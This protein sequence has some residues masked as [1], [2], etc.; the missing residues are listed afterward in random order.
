MTVWY[1][2]NST[3]LREGIS[4]TDCFCSE[5]REISIHCHPW[6]RAQGLAIAV[7]KVRGD[8]RTCMMLD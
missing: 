2:E 8:L 3:W 6:G 5:R 7:T 1:A 4:N